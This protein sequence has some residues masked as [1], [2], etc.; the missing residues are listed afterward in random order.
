MYPLYEFSSSRLTNQHVHETMADAEFSYNAKQSFGTVDFDT[1][2]EDPSLT[3]R[4]VT[5]DGEQVFAKTLR[6]ST[7]GGR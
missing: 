4:I 5:I 1:T 3:Y 2:I 6:L 7:L